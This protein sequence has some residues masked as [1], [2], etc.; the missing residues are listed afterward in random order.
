M[1]VLHAERRPAAS[2][3]RSPATSGS[4]IPGVGDAEDQRRV[5]RRARRRSS[6]RCRRT[7]TSP[8]TTTSRSTSRPS[9]A[10]ST[11]SARCRCT[12][13]YV[14]TRQV[15]RPA[16]RPVRRR[17]A[18]SSTARRRW[19]RT[20]PVRRDR[21]RHEYY[22]RTGNGWSPPTPPPTSGASSASRTS[23]RSSG[24]IAVQRTLDDPLDRARPRRQADPQPPGRR[25]VRPRRVQRARAR[26]HGPHVRTT[27][28]ASQ[29]ET[30][31]WYD[32][33]KPVGGQSVLLAK[34]PEAD[35]VLAQLR[36]EGRLQPAP[37]TTVAPAARSS[38]RCGPATC[39]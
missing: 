13:P 38:R 26:V 29:F 10:S 19:L 28:R 36:G 4:T 30:L 21:R 35:A 14:T 3:C 34:Q 5:Q 17:A 27:A 9:R 8:S 15:H 32:R 39:G 18:T 24:G 16:R 6:T 37:T 33:G 2:R 25:R 7:S 23:S 12:F 20:G 31:P 1:M 22:D 11:P